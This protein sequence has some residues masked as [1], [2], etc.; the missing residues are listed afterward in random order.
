[1]EALH[2]IEHVGRPGS[3]MVFKIVIQGLV[4]EDLVL[5]EKGA[6]LLFDVGECRGPFFLSKRM[7]Y[8]VG[9]RN[10]QMLVFGMRVDILFPSSCHILIFS[11]IGVS[12]SQ[13]ADI[14]SATFEKTRLSGGLHSMKE[15]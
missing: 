15:N 1:M 5:Q 8:V 4:G 2:D 12:F 13:K 10:P 6:E 3:W 11:N 7:Q 9:T 14:W